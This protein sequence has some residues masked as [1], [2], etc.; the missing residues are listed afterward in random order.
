MTPND[1]IEI[2]KLIAPAAAAWVS[3]RVGIAVATERA[4][5]ALKSADLA[6]QRLD[7]F[8]GNK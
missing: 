6:H 8:I 3:V 4:D 1:L 2:F 5:Q 7:T